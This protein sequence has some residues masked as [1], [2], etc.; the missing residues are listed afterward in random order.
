MKPNPT[1]H[2]SLPFHRLGFSL[3]R[4]LDVSPGFHGIKPVIRHH[5]LLPRKT[6]GLR[7]API[8]TMIRG[9]LPPGSGFNALAPIWCALASRL[10]IELSVVFLYFLRGT[11]GWMALSPVQRHRRRYEGCVRSLVNASRVNIAD[12]KQNLEKLRDHSAHW[13]LAGGSE[14]ELTN[15]RPSRCG[16][17]HLAKEGNDTI[18]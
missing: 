10:R 7:P 11:K 18:R 8:H 1:D 2:R 12:S 5:R 17:R 4:S 13:K 16:S 6:T 9:L 15:N 14:V 3:R